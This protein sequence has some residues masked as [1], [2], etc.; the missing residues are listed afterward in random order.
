MR[1]K[2]RGH[3]YGT[4]FRSGIT[5]R[6]GKWFG[7]YKNPVNTWFGHQPGCCDYWISNPKEIQNALIQDGHRTKIVD[8]KVYILEEVEL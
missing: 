7:K 2:F 6:F 3:N 1:F 5:S 4:S 8:G